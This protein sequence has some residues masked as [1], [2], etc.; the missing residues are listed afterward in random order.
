[1]ERLV[2][3]FGFFFSSLLFASASKDE[4]QSDEKQWEP[5][6]KKT[7]SSAEIKKACR[8]YEGK[9][10]GYYG[11]VFL[12]SKCKRREVGSHELINKL[13][14]KGKVLKQVDGDVIVKIPAGKVYEVHQKKRSCQS[15][16][17]Q[18]ITTGSKGIFYVKHC[19]IYSFPDWETYG[20]HRKSTRSVAKPII[21]I[22]NEEFKRFKKAKELPT[23]LDEA[24][25]RLLSEGADADYIPIK[26]ACR[27]VEGR[28]VSYYSHFYYIEKCRK[29]AI[30]G[31][32]F[33]R[34]R[35]LKSSVIELSTEQ[36]LSLP[37]GKPKGI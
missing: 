13:V 12:V 24:Y 19:D 36:W 1:M 29:R 3:V 32:K 31:Q 20:E 14:S 15:L 5:P 7:F 2:L 18:Y 16:E 27:G 17:G 21:E 22:S 26:E 33:F 10:I 8:Q 30:D 9:L 34:K 37:E 6:K 28:Y 25:S 23:I 4:N 35:R 11:R